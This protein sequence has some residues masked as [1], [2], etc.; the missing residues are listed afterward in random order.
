MAQN[1]SHEERMAAYKKLGWSKE[2]INKI[3]SVSQAYLI[4][5]KN[6]SIDYQ[7]KILKQIMKDQKIKIW[8]K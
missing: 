4:D 7:T 8:R 3:R 6:M 2:D 5:Q 1:L